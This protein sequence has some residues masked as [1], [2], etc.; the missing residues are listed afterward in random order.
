MVKLIWLLLAAMM[1]LGFDAQIVRSS[2]RATCAEQTGLPICKTVKRSI[3]ARNQF[4]RQTGHPHGWKGHVVDHI[5]PLAC[6]GLDG[7]L[8]MQ[9]QTIEE[10]KAKDRTELQCCIHRPPSRRLPSRK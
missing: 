2:E 6:G 8:N 3:A 1:A 4:M 9:W 10:A 7:S 5:I